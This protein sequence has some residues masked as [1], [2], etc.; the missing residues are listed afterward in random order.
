MIRRIPGM[1]GKP[2]FI[3]LPFLLLTSCGSPQ[4]EVTKSTKTY[5]FD[6]D[7]TVAKPSSIMI[8]CA[9]GG[10]YVEKISWES[11]GPSGA[12]G[13]GT[14][15]YNDCDPDC[16]DG[17]MHSVP[18]RVTLTKLITFKSKNYLSAL[19]I[20]TLDGKPLSNTEGSTFDWDLSDFARMMSQE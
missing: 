10:A 20:E 12:Q 15:T 11:W 1:R 19:H 8:Y 3:I 7:T 4:A 2:L 9:D 13:S 16:A 6:C 14:Y 18:I 17:T 5:T